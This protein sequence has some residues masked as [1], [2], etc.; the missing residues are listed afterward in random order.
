MSEAR[1][2]GSRVGR[3]V[4]SGRLGNGLDVDGAPL[5]PWTERDRRTERV[6]GLVDEP[7]LDVAVRGHLLVGEAATDALAIEG[8]AV[9]GVTV[10]VTAGGVGVDDQ[11]GLAV[12]LDDLGDVHGLLLWGASH[13]L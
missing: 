12:D 13:G 11:G 9:D 1:G 7:G 4:L 5:V 6:L 8:H 10:L 3:G 2:S